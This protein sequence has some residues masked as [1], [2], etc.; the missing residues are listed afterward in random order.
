MPQRDAR[1]IVEHR[2]TVIPEL[3]D[4]EASAL[5]VLGKELRGMESNWNNDDEPDG[6]SD[7]TR[8]N[9]TSVIK[10]SREPSDTG[11]RIQVSNAIGVIG[12]SDLQINVL[13]KIGEKHFNYVASRAVG[14]AHLRIGRETFRLESDESFLPAVWCAFLNALETTLRADLPQDYEERDDDP[15]YIRGRLDVRRVSLNISRGVLRFRSTFEELTYDNSVNRTLRAAAELV[16]RAS[17]LAA[18]LSP[19]A[20]RDRYLLLAARSREAV[21]RIGDVGPLR[22]HDL[23][24][25]VPR[26]AAHQAEALELAKHIL[27]GIGRS[28]IVGEVA[29]SC[30]LQPTPSIVE[31]GIREILASRLGSGVSVAKRRRSAARLEFNP[32]L[33]VEVVN[34][35]SDQ[36]RATGDVKYRLRKDDWQRDVLQQAVT[37]AQV[38]TAK[39]AFFIDF[40]DESNVLTQSEVIREVEYH[41]I[42]WP[43]ASATEPLSA[44]D[45][46]VGELRRVLLNATS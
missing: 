41:H 31:D 18:P 6:R 44:E 19:G 29:V 34:D 14:P 25:P 38:F 7:D 43:C 45:Y 36:P 37:F 10:V 20:A 12:V 26:I 35:A 46:V 16:G 1:D 39:K 5:Q 27:S 4:D 28:L 2:S 3:S 15:S 30:F 11:W 24:S 13:P 21:Y 22:P 40:S 33:V 32:D 8:A 23:D 17:E 42:T 9:E